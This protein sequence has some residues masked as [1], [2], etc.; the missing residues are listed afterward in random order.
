M[1]KL[2]IQLYTLREESKKDF[3]SVIKFCADKGFDGV[4]F[5]GFYGKS[6]ETIKEW[7]NKYNIVATS[8]HV[9]IDDLKKDLDGIMNFH[10]FIGNKRI[11]IPY[12][13]ANDEQTTKELID[14]LRPII[15]I[16]KAN[17]FDV[18]YHNHDHEL[19]RVNG[20]FILDYLC[21]E[22]KDLKL[23][24]DTFWVYAAKENTCEFLENHVDRLGDII[25]VK[26]GFDASNCTEKQKTQ[27]PKEAYGMIEKGNNMI[28]C[29]IGLGT[30]PIADVIKTAKSLNVEWIVLENDFPY[31]SGFED[32]ELS[33]VTLK[34]LL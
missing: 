32:V 23:E 4:E 13:L 29:A 6:K 2:S 16:L 3:E 11:V 21:D 33:L 17:D 19:T 22:F 30:A 5:A 31:A 7:L 20:K 8:A 1:T 14:T 34:D 18:Y 27:L 12:F 28:P 9:L 15:K 10:K 24:V 26:D 25:H